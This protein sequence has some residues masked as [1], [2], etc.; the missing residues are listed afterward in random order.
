MVRFTFVA[1]VIAFLG[2]VAFASCATK[3]DDKE[4]RCKDSCIGGPDELK[5]Q[6]FCEIEAT[7]CRKRC[8][9]K[10]CEYEETL[11]VKKCLGGP[12]PQKCISLCRDRGTKCRL[13]C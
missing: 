6:S 8:C 10:R 4:V 2:A 7:N 11:C 9:I 3:C 12:R 13:R 5:C 1:I